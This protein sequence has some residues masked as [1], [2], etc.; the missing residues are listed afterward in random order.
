MK[1]RKLLTVYLFLLFLAVATMGSLWWFNK[2]KQHTIIPR[3]YNEIREEG[4]LRIIT[5]YSPSGYYISGD[6]IEGFQYELSQAIAQISGME[7]QTL[8]EMSLSESFKALDEN[9]CDII[10]QNIPITSEIREK[11]LFTDPIV[12][13]KQVLIQRTVEANNGTEPI[14]NQLDLA[15]KTIYVPHNSP[16]LL[17]LQ[18]LEHEI[19][20]TIHII[21]EV[22]YSSEQLAI[23]VA[24]GDIDFAVCD[25]QAARTFKKEFPEI[26]IDTDISFTQLQAWAVRI[27][28]PILADS[29][30][31]WLKRIREEGIYDKIYKRYYDNQRK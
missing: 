15:N 22:A 17:R 10:A 3:D 12:M 23:M 14:R 11:Y 18:H 26:D 9:K 25:L 29:L 4:I 2:T 28:S 6:T 5:E 27:N 21:E 24:K 8:L 13:N 16:A 20:D 30:N 7:V 19:G 1:S 31:N